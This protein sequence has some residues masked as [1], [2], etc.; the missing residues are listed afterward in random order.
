MMLLA[1][2]AVGALISVK[3]KWAIGFTAVILIIGWVMTRPA[4]AAWMTCCAGSATGSGR[5]AAA[6]VSTASWSRPGPCW[7]FWTRPKPG[8]KA[9]PPKPGKGRG[10]GTL[11][12]GAVFC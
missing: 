9:A 7:T 12:P 3:L 2:L 11:E 1:P 8:L 6:V 10:T 4:V 5:S